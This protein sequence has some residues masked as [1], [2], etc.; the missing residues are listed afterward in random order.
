MTPAGEATF[1]TLM[2]ET[3]KKLGVTHPSGVE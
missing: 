1:M 3:I 2:L